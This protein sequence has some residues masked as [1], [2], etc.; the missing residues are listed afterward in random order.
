MRLDQLIRRNVSQHRVSSGLT[1]LNVA[2]G[3]ALV[4]AVLLLRAA[5]ADTFLK[6]SRGY[7]LVVGAPGSS[8]ELVLNSVFHLGQSPGLLDYSVFEELEANGSTQ[9]AVPYAVGDAFRGYRVVG[10]SEA[11]FMPRFPYPSADSAAAKLA[12]GR[13]FHFDR[14]ALRAELDAIA[15]GVPLHGSDAAIA[16][17]PGASPAPVDE[18]VIG[19]EVARALEIQVG[20]QIEPTHGVEGAGVSHEQQRLWRVVGVLKRTDTPV[21]KLVLI[22]LDSFFRI[23]D[24]K[25]GVIPETGRPGISAVLLF[26]KPGVHK[27]LLLGQLN[28]RTQLQV[29]DVDTEVHRLLGL[30]GNVDRVF[31]VIAV[32]VVLVGVVSVAVAIYNTLAARARELS[33]LRILGARR[34]TVFGMLVGEAALLSALGGLLGLLLAHALVFA[35]AGLVEQ[36]AGFRPKSALFLPEELLVYVLVVLAGAAGGLLPAVRAYKNEAAAQLAPLA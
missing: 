26:P 3:V 19:A 16:S 13:P 20:D 33:I 23:S 32:L 9:L 28:K 17:A 1:L 34:S 14:A 22:N 27:A 36:S 5:T 35:T 21:D 2:L 15:A 29:A 18:A 4:G 8:L 31:L 24:H 6:P 25:G 30:I 10:T 12:S 7:G 11:F